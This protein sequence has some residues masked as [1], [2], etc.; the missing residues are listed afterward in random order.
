MINLIRPAP[1]QP[2]SGEGAQSPHYRWPCA[3]RLAAAEAH[4]QDAVG[5]ATV[6]GGGR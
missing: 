4:A 1:A 3:T 6:I 5:G 2:K